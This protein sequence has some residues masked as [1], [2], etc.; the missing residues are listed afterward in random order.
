MLRHA[1][2]YSV[3]LSGAEE[4]SFTRHCAELCLLCCAALC[5]ALQAESVQA[6]TMPAR[7]EQRVAFMHMPII[8]NVKSMLLRREDQ[9][10]CMQ[11]QSTASQQSAQNV[12]Y[13]G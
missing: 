5:H 8:I 13:R 11:R 6:F 3:E 4:C 2:L 10:R 1:L 12:M 7:I 9:A